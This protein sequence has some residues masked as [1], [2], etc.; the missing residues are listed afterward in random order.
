[1]SVIVAASE[2]ARAAL[3]SFLALE[4]AGGLLLVGAAA[5]GML[6]ANTPIERGYHDLLSLPLT[7][8][9]GA[10][11]VDK[12]LLYWINDGLMALFFLLVG[13]ELK[14]EAVEGQFA[15]RRQLV[16]PAAC[17]LG[18]M[19]VPM[20]FYAAVNHGDE[21]G[22]RGLAIP[23]ATDIAFALGVL[24]LLGSRVPFG[25][26]L[27]LTAIAVLDDV[28]AIVIIAAFYTSELSVASLGI[29]LA[30]FGGLVVLNRTGVA[31]LQPYF[32]LGAVMWLA[33]LES[34]VHATLAGVALGLTIPLADRKVPERSPLAEAEHALHPWVAYAILPLFA[35]ANAG[36]PLAGL[37]FADLLQPIPLGILLGLV[38]GKPI[39]VLAF[40]GAVLA[41]RL[42]RLPEGV[43]GRALAG[44]AMLCGVG[45]TMSL[46]IA[47]LA[48]ETAGPAA[49]LSARA[50]IVAASLVAAG[51]G[52]A[53]LRA[54]L[55]P[56]PPAAVSP[57]A[58]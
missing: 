27:L 43:S 29:A 46:F 47:T 32:V 21:T 2:R 49:R 48:F 40:G 17:A 30:A 41:L 26:K 13:L 15:D 42:A 39:G 33:V 1:M 9:L 12:P 53:W 37:S 45:F 58:S 28:G 56:V 6:A 34:G 24:A 20:A 3:T 23:S 5:L 7:V 8:K 54:T 25:L 51:L 38:L 55:R 18:G 16:F 10:I 22:M 35:F 44:A 52:Y 19:I 14:R 57:S 31:R 36:V 50:A 11:G 4:S